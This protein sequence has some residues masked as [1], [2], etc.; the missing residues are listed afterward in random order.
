VGQRRAPGVYAVVGGDSYLAELAVE[1]ILE[2]A[3]G[4]EGRSDSVQTLRGD[5]TPWARL[6]DLARTR[7]L[8][9]ER[10]AILVRG[11]EAL[12]GAEEGLT[13]YLADPTPGVALILL[14]AKPD[15][16]KTA[17]KRLLEAAEVVTAEPLKGGALRAKV[18]DELRQRGL[19][20]DADALDELL[21]R[22][23]GN[24]R[25]LMGEID[26][27]QA[28]A[29]GRP[30]LTAEDVAAVLGRGLAR[31]LYA[32]SDALCSRERELALRLLHEALEEGEA[33]VYVLGALHRSLRTLRAV[34]S[35]RG[36]SWGEIASRLRVPPFK[37]KYLVEAGGRWTDEELEEA[38]SALGKAD[39]QLKTS[40]DPRVALLV[41]VGQ[42]C[43]EGRAVSGAQRRGR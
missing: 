21:E 9:A 24:L 19:A 7:S 35:L 16:R 40:V 8:F 1:K 11:A 15:K 22:V 25:R 32:L 14:A 34:R 4:L 33:P 41:A 36:S 30:R 6:L 29:E 2:R 18:A 42:A 31:P 10:R 28:F 43:G 17:W 39:R 26:K 27:L 23:G 38:T 37:V 13:E 20:M 3:V 5:E 12:K